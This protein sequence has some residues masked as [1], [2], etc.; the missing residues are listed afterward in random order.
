ML[1]HV[2]LHSLASSLPPPLFL[3]ALV[4][5]LLQSTP[6]SLWVRKFLL[7]SGCL[8][9]PSLSPLFW[10]KEAP[11]FLFCIRMSSQWILFDGT[12]LD[13]HPSSL[14]SFTCL[15]PLPLQLYIFFSNLPSSSCCLVKR[16]RRYSLCHFCSNP[17]K[18]NRHQTLPLKHPLL[19][20]TTTTKVAMTWLKYLGLWATWAFQAL[21]N[22]TYK[23]EKT[24]TT[25]LKKVIA[26][27]KDLSHNGIKLPNNCSICT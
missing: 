27:R 23:T 24:T 12:H 6:L 15:P 7:L 26:K 8:A 4:I 18:H 1:A 2:H 14:S 9:T 5:S 3:S 19:P 13:N 11:F 25:C 22:V 16:V 10:T 21:A 17:S 20:T